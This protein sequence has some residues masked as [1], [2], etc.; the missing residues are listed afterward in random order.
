MRE[1]YNICIK[2]KYSYLGKCM[3]KALVNRLLYI[4]QIKSS[5]TYL[6]VK[7]I[8]LLLQICRF[9]LYSDNY[10]KKFLLILFLGIQ[11]RS[12]SSL[13]TLETTMPS[14]FQ[15]NIEMTTAHSMTIFKVYFQRNTKF[16]IHHKMTILCNGTVNH[17]DFLILQARYR[18]QAYPLK[19]FIYLVHI[20]VIQTRKKNILY[21]FIYIYR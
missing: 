18:L 20:K 12:W 19:M 17:S 5:L 16:L 3:V 2:C 6:K 1:I 8:N 9:K 13:K 11:G 15:R 4:G 21:I 10:L 14:D 7:R